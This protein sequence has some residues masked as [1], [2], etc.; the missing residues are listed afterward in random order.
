MA[1]GHQVSSLSVFCSLSTLKF[2]CP[3]GLEEDGTLNDA[4]EDSGMC[5]AHLQDVFKCGPAAAMNNRE[6]TAGKYY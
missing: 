6:K 3:A 1:M 2:C 4:N 5:V